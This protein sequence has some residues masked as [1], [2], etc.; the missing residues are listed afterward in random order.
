MA[1]I[2]DV[3]RHAGVSAATVS[4]ALNGATSVDPALKRRVLASA[5]TLRYQPNGVARNLRRQRTA[6]WMLLISDIENP[7][8]PAVARGVE[9]VARAAGFSLV[10]CNSDEDLAKERAYISGALQERAAGVLLAPASS[11][12]DISPLVDR[13]V[14]VVTFDRGLATA[15][16]DSVVTDSE[17]GAREATTHLLEQGW[18]RIACITG[19]RQADTA[20]RRVLG[21]QQALTAWGSHAPFVVDSDFRSEGGRQA[22]RQL[23]DRPGR[24]DAVFVANNLMALGVLAELADRGLR[25]G[26]DVGV[27]AFDDPPWATLLDPPLAAVAQ[28]AYDLGRAAAQLL[29]E[30]ATGTYTGA[31]RHLSLPCELHPRA[32]AVRP[33]S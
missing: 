29:E 23:L 32:S 2:H 26:R 30:R 25:P 5:E 21:Y 28:P 13:G 33:V 4:R 18:K 22:M 27:V 6:L 11:A 19:P 15:D 8:F 9:D 17:T 14:P 1:T 7:F 3:A 24:P 10:L 31:A 20:E 16:V 12:T